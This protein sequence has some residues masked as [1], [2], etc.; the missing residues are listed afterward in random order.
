MKIPGLSIYIFF[1]RRI[2]WLFIHIVYAY[3]S[4]CGICAHCYI[5]ITLWP[6]LFRPATDIDH[7][8][9]VTVLIHCNISLCLDI[10]IWEAF[11]I[12]DCVY[13]QFNVAF[14]YLNKQ[15]YILYDALYLT[16]KY[17]SLFSPALW[18]LWRT[19]GNPREMPQYSIVNLCWSGYT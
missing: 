14:L 7:M 12:L 18:Y 9:Y 17:S 16:D 5:S 1:Y 3:V 8:N 19:P 11:Y 15:S 10:I 6:K 13:G 2:A 4:I